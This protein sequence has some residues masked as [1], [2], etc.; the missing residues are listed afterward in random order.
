MAKALENV[1]QK[2]T[3]ISCKKYK[4]NF[5]KMQIYKTEYHTIITTHS[6]C[7]NLDSFR[8]DLELV[9]NADETLT[10]YGMTLSL[11]P[12]ETKASTHVSI[13]SMLCEAE[14]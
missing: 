7:C 3:Q 11:R 5:Q 14:S 4:D 8:H 10:H 12:M 2:D 6:S 1:R 9:T 13:S